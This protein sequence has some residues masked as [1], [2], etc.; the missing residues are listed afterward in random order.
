MTET[1]RCTPRTAASAAPLDHRLRRMVGPRPRRA[2]S[3]RDAARAALRPHVRRRVQPGRQPGR[4][5][6]RARPLRARDPRLLVRGV[7]D[8]PGR[9]STT[10][11]SPRPTTTTTSS[12]ASR[13]WCR[14]SA[15]SCSPS[16]CPTFHS[17]DEGEHLDNGVMVAGYVIMRVA[18]IALWLRIA[19][20]DAAH[21]RSALTY[22]V[23]VGDPPGRLG[24]H[25]LRQP[26]AVRHALASSSCLG[27]LELV[28]PT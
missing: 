22:A 19:R 8:L 2:A 26:A 10:R 7:R 6:A 17:I 28:C 13:P 25:H 9:G 15:S 27:A 23:V 20:H 5:P 4:A 16:A 11:G 18:T 14:C 12:S 21:R 24:G 3:H 1:S